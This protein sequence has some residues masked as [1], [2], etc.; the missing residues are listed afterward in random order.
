MLI[1]ILRT[2]SV[3]LVFLQ[4]PFSG[5]FRNSCI[6]IL[7]FS[8][9]DHP[10]LQIYNRIVTPAPNP[11]GKPKS[12]AA[13]QPLQ[14]SFSSRGR[15]NRRA[16]SNLQDLSSRFVTRTIQEPQKFTDWGEWDSAKTTEEASLQRGE[17]ETVCKRKREQR[18]QLMVDDSSSL[19]HWDSSDYGDS[20]D[21]EDEEPLMVQQNTLLSRHQGVLFHGKDVIL[22]VQSEG[23][24]LR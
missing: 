19:D 12:R 2:R 8:S 13:R 14:Y 21:S 11:K 4:T 10:K 6:R 16:S 22:L 15:E 23:A 9:Q 3:D 24:N 7:L 17:K 1:Q 18:G 5:R 20:S